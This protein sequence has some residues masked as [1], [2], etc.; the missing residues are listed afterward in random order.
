M[1]IT[2]LWDVVQCILADKYRRFRRTCRH[3]HG[4]NSCT[5][6]KLQAVSSSATLVLICRT[7]LCHIPEDRT[8]INVKQ[9]HLRN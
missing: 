2:V 3:R 9:I 8:Q 6:L 7:T 4:R 5:T 1:K